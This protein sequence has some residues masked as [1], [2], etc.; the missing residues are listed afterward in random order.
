MAKFIQLIS[1][2][3]KRPVSV[4]IDNITWISTREV[5]NNLLTIVHFT[6]AYSDS[7]VSLVVAESYD[8][9]TKLIQKV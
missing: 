5:N 4:N 3:T 9:V 1:N 2:K 6:A 7:T 8:Q